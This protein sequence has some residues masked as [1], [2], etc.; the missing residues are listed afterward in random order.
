MVHRGGRGNKRGGGGGY[1]PPSQGGRGK[2]GRGG[3]DNFTP[4]TLSRST[5]G[6]DP[7]FVRASGSGNEPHPSFSLADE[8]RNT[9]IHH[10]NWKTATSLRHAKIGFVSAG[11]LEPQDL[12]KPV[13][14][15]PE[16]DQPTTEATR[17]ES[18]VELSYAD[19]LI[20]NS[21]GG[22]TRKVD[23][24]RLES[25]ISNSGPPEKK[26][27]KP[28]ETSDEEIPG[29]IVDLVGD[30]A[31]VLKDPIPMRAPS[32]T[33]SQASSSSSEKIVFVPRRLRK[34]G[35]SKNILSKD[36]SK[37][38]TRK[39]SPPNTSFE[40]GAPNG[41]D[42]T[43][44]VSQVAHAVEDIEAEIKI[45]KRTTKVLTIHDPISQPP[46][47][48]SEERTSPTHAGKN[49]KGRS[50]QGNKS[51]KRAR[52]RQSRKEEEEAAIEDYLENLAA[53]MRE[54][55][56]EEGENDGENSTS[57]LAALLN[58]RDLGGDDDEWVDE[59]STDED[60]A[61]E[62]SDAVARYKSNLWSEDD[63]K[64]FDDISTSDEGPIGLVETILGKRKRPSGLQYLI[65]WAGHD[66]DDATWVLAE[67]LD[68]SS[69]AKLKT[70]E[71]NLAKREAM[72]QAANDDSST[73]EEHEEDEDLKLAKLLQSQE[74]GLDSD[75]DMEELEADFMA[76]D[77]F[78]PLGKGKGKRRA[79]PLV[80]HILPNPRT[81]H[82]PSASRMANAYDDFDV[83]D[84]E[85]ASLTAKRKSKGKG[86]MPALNLS[87]SELEYQIENSWQKD[88]EKKKARKQEREALRAE[89]LLGRKAQ[90][91]GKRNAMEKYKEG[92]TTDEIFQDIKQ[93]MM[94]T[95]DSLSLPPMD[96][97]TRKMVHIMAS[98]FNLKSKSIGSGHKRFPTLYK[99]SRSAIY[100]QNEETIEAIM[101]HP[102]Y[103]PRSDVS[104]RN[105]GGPAISVR[106]GGGGGGGGGGHHREGDIVGASAP[107]IAAENR[108]RRMLEKMGYKAG[109]SL[110]LDSSKGI[111]APIA[112]VVKVSKAGLG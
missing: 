14:Q 81:G 65:K 22:V 17:E 31:L 97:T 74:M 44:D 29:F 11:Q 93:F 42:G 50:T 16:P 78:F 70:Y 23:A 91:T 2:R 39:S 87:D 112:A 92:M 25:E 43:H 10:G 53:Q 9:E 35:V 13:H 40:S 86:K 95:H 34:S 105:R 107:E 82:F 5:S 52:H 37:A 110:G 45:T 106:R 20:D 88:R 30:P 111:I 75:L 1:S 4:N 27:R 28:Q 12:L 55:E 62:D 76:L 98:A 102:R 101:R 68:S 26:S 15:A 103:F 85:R 89:G 19:L 21:N 32:P 79:K 41:N 6:P 38:T 60:E 57:I 104:G 47:Q 80:P 54:E 56:A 24:Q 108:G 33:P 18:N 99:T 46:T 83:M 58:K 100:E 63:L 7:Y 96:K 67:K 49:W 77:D 84:W 69:D 90:K 94:S 51:R 59:S 71:E 64:D 48:I 36:T 73:D 8:A 3:G 66:T 72:A 61:A 109:T